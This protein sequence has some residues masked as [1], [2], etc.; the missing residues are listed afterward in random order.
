M[1]IFC[2]HVMERRVTNTLITNMSGLLNQPGGHQHAKHFCNYCLY[3]F[4]DMSTLLQH[5]EDCFKF[6]PQKVT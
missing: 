6:G 2:Y 5:T 3:G 4:V 1:R